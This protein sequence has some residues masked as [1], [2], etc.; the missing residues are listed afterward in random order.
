MK[1]LLINPNRYKF[2]P[3]PP[4]GLEYLAACLEH[5]GHKT[6][7]IDLCFSENLYEDIDNALELFNPDITG[8]TVRNVDTVLYHTNEFFLDELKDI[9]KH[10][11]SKHGL[12]VIIGGTGLSTNAEGVLEYLDADFAI[13]GPAENTLNE[14]L[15]EIGNS[16]NTKKIWHGRLRNNIKCSRSPFKVDYKRYFESGGIAGFETHKGCTSS[17][18]YCIEANSRVFFKNVHDVISEIK[19]FVD[20]G[21]KHFH[22][23]DSEFNENLEYAIDFCSAMKESGLDIK[24]AVYMKPSEFSR[25]LFRLMKETGVYLITLTVD[26]YQKCT[27]Y[28]SDIEKFIFT[29]K[30]CGIKVAVDFLTGFPYEDENHILECIG[31]LKRLQPDSVS[32]NTFIRLYK[33]LQIT[34]II[35]G[36]SKLREH[37]SG[38]IDDST[39]IKP[40]FYNQ[41]GTEKLEQLIGGD[42]LFRIEGPERSVNYI[43]V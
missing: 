13:V 2:P 27:A 38:N 24:W 40:V 12:K 19:M 5:G 26:S 21:Y 35:L 16:G 7:I 42:P 30:S 4:I 17:C 28:W 29:A 22:L 43:R 1:I 10:I 37:L 8:I 20:I 14:L 25:R 36:D 33:N 34:N 9:V 32:I 15:N 3:V 39:F 6:E 11:K 41:I 23:C 31:T 18:V